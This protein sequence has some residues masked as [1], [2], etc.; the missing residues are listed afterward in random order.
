MYSKGYLAQSKRMKTGHRAR[1]HC[2]R[3]A[4]NDTPPMTSDG[5][6]GI[7]PRIGATHTPSPEYDTMGLFFIQNNVNMTSEE[8]IGRS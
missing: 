2:S 6:G 3:K 7:T 1:I 4:H 8:T 5:G